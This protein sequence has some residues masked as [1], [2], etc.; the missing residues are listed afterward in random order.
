MALGKGL[1]LGMRGSM[2][3]AGGEVSGACLGEWDVGISIGCMRMGEPGEARAGT[4]A[5]WREE[6]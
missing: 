6:A 2:E 1:G 3:G 4:A 5:G